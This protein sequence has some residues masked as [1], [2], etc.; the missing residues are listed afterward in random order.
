MKTWIWAL[1]GVVALVVVLFFL[2]IP[3][4]SQVATITLDW[5]APGDD[6]NVGTATTYEMRWSTTRPDTT[7]VPNMDNW[8]NLA[9][10][11]TSMPTP[12]PSGSAQSKAVAGPFTTG[13]TY[14][15]VIRACDEVPNC[16]PYSNVA[17][18]FIPDA[19]PPSRIIDLRT[20]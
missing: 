16:S 18:K 5:T 3:V 15:F 4:H 10:T 11:V 20:R 19:M 13:Q 6:G 14:Y 9:T 17:S 1:I 8:W 12:L 2:P 7:T